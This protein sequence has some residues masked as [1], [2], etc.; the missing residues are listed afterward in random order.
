MFW[1]IL[2]NKMRTANC[3]SRNVYMIFG[4]T[5]PTFKQPG[6]LTLWPNHCGL[7]RV[8]HW[9]PFGTR[10]LLSSSFS[11]EMVS[12]LYVLIS[13]AL[14]FDTL[15]TSENVWFRRRFQSSSPTRVVDLFVSFLILPN[16]RCRGQRIQQM[17]Q[18]RLSVV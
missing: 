16:Y 7:S 18:G 5:W 2:V 6:P 3:S 11:N 15:N 14:T 13:H 17:R 10:T 8:T 9:G 4:V 1:S 12:N